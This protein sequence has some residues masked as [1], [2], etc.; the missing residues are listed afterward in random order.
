MTEGGDVTKSSGGRLAWEKA[1]AAFVFE[2]REASGVGGQGL[3]LKFIASLGLQLGV[4]QVLSSPDV[5]TVNIQPKINV[6]NSCVS[7]SVKA[8][9]G[10]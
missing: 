10:V 4:S 2:I 9:R 3:G 8:K 1:E 7:T 5:L 6:P